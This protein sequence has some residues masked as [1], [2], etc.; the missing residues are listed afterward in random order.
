MSEK[1][2]FF[3]D[4]KNEEKGRISMSK[5]LDEIR[6]LE[7]EALLRH[8]NVDLTPP[9]DLSELAR[10]IG[11]SIYAFDFS[12]LEEKHNIPKGEIIGA[13][14]SQDE[15]VN[16]FYASQSTRNRS[17][18]TI[19]HELGHACLHTEDFELSHIELRTESQTDERERKA[20]IFAGELLIPAASLNDVIS[21]L[22][23]P[24]LT[25]L[26][27]IFEVSVNVMRARLVHLGKL[28]LV[29]D[30]APKAIQVE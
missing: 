25:A 27:N 20:D 3:L 15:S 10:K 23:Q 8:Y 6:G 21:M 7:A 18:F 4:F 17:R 5:I 11:I 1:Y 29:V 30:D 28:S 14:I 22:I 9:I 16:V 2:V 12:E 13:A 24:K 26:A 19:A